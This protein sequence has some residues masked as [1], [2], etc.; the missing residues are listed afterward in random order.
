M[1]NI[2]MWIKLNGISFEVNRFR[3]NLAAN[4][5]ALRANQTQVVF[6]RRIGVGQ[7]T[8]NRL[9]QGMQNIT[10]DTLETICDRLNCTTGDLLEK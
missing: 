5:R 1:H 6:A 2:H 9:E 10:I 3:K 8:L 7:S 4:L